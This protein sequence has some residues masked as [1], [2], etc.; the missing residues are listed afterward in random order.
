MTKFYHIFALT[1]LFGC[2]AVMYG[3]NAQQNTRRDSAETHRAAEMYGRLIE[4]AH[5]TPVVES[6]REPTAAEVFQATIALV[7]L[8]TT[9]ES[10]AFLDVNMI[11]PETDQFPTQNESSIAV[12]PK[13]PKNLIASA[14]DY[15]G[16]SSTWVYVSDDAGK[17]WRNMN[18]GKPFPTWTSSNDP[19]VTFDAD[20]TGYLMYGGFGNRAVANFENGVFLARTPDGG[21]TWKAHIPVILH[22]GTQTADSNLEDK[23]Y[24]HTDNS[25]QSPYFG[26]VYTPWKRVVARD[27]STQIV[28]T[29]ST[30]KGET[31]SIPVPVSARL[32]GSSE[33]TTFGQSFPLIRTGAAGEGYCFWNYGPQHGIG[34]AT[35]A[36]GGATWSAPRIIHTYRPLGTAKRINEGIRHTLKGV[37]RVEAYP[38][39]VCDLT[40]SSRRGWLYLAWAADVVPSIYFS[41]STDGGATWSTPK[42]IHENQNNDQFWPWLALDPTNGDIAVMYLDSRDDNENIGTNCY[43]SYSSNG[44]DTWKDLRAS[45]T[46]SDLRRNPFPGNN[47]AGDYSGCAFHNGIIYPS[48]VDMRNTAVNVADNDAYTAVIN[49]RI[50]RPAEPFAAKTLPALPTEIDLSWTPPTERVLG[51]PLAAAEFNHV[52]YRNGTKITELSGSANSYRDTGLTPYEKY[53][54]VIVAAAGADTSAPRAA[55]AFAGGSRLPEKPNLLSAKGAEDRTVRLTVRVPALRSDSITPFVNPK[56]L[57]IYRDSIK[58]TESPITVA[59]TGKTVVITDVPNERGWYR[60]AVTVTDASTPSNESAITPTITLYTGIV[61]PSFLEK[62]EQATVPHYLLS[63]SW[64]RSATFGNNSSASLTN[65]VNGTYSNSDRDTMMIYPVLTAQPRELRFFHAAIIHPSDTAVVETSADGGDT[66]LRL[67]AFNKIGFAPWED[68]IMNAADWREEKFTLQQA[69]TTLIRFRFTSNFRNND[70]GWFVDDIS[71][72]AITG[73]ESDVREEKTAIY[74]NPAQTYVV[75]RLPDE[76]N[77]SVEVSTMTGAAVELPSDAVRQSGSHLTIAVTTLPNGVYG[78]RCTLPDGTR[79]ATPFAVWR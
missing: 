30:D 62:F 66:W 63:D 1:A 46:Y 54:Y 52:L 60:Y 70:V 33:D 11:E 24:V 34:F 4:S 13:N 57:I 64:N 58:I 28:S 72:G 40:N 71:V 65:S 22:Q 56:A 61:E 68:G 29:F 41:R 79:I 20:G 49:L 26:R 77:V 50:P 59:D 31:W 6:E 3:M 14:V 36:N 45:D 15:R 27:S 67:G 51:K 48:W 38:T 75:V 21:K 32:S 69:D 73:V 7:P 25:P 43:V 12:N 42:V 17:T 9:G 23:Y 19:S 16:Q 44:G 78:I 2:F 8:V 37:V 10:S 55:T 35:S 47:F 39:A 74:P 18:L 76:Y 53:D 5:P